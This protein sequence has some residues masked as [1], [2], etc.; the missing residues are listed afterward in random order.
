MIQNR[1]ENATGKGYWL[2]IK[3]YKTQI[4]LEVRKPYKEIMQCQIYFKQYLVNDN[5]LISKSDDFGYLQIS[6]RACILGLCHLL[7][8]T[9]FWL[10][11]FLLFSLHLFLLFSLCHH[12]CYLMPSLFKYD[13][14]LISP[15]LYRWEFAPLTVTW[16]FSQKYKPYIQHGKKDVQ[17]A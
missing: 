10:S 13:W 1:S 17:S 5:L 7:L 16:D 9:L 2:Q 3:L 6:A 15:H 11:I 14:K 12:L 4:T 8:S